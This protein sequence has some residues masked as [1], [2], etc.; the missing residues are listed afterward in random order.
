MVDDLSKKALEKK[1]EKLEKEK[2]KVED[3]VEKEK[4]KVRE[5]VEKEKRKLELKLAKE[6]AKASANKFKGEFKK[7]LSTAVVAAFSFLIALSWRE[8]ITTYVNLLTAFSP[9]QGQLITAIIITF[10]GVIGIVLAT[11]LLKE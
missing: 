4:E 10:I 1:V 5:K 6:K 7:A 2:E 11:W 9:V 3:K 8:L